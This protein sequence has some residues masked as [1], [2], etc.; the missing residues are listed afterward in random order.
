MQLLVVVVVGGRGG[1]GASCFLLFT[2]CHQDYNPTAATQPRA[3]A[4]CRPAHLRAGPHSCSAAAAT[5]A[6]NV[7]AL[8]HAR[9]HGEA[10]PVLAGGAGD[11]ACD[12]APA[13]KHS[14][15]A[16]VLSPSYPLAAA[17][18]RQGT[19]EGQQGNGLRGQRQG[20]LHS[21]ICVLVP[22]AQHQ[23]FR[24]GSWAHTLRAYSRAWAPAAARG[25]LRAA[26]C[27]RGC[28]TRGCCCK[29]WGCRCAGHLPCAELC[30]PPAVPC[31]PSDNDAPPAAVARASCKMRGASKRGVQYGG[32]PILW[33]RARPA[34][35]VQHRQCGTLV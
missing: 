24:P 28:C 10:Q 21:C 3:P 6:S 23:R 2:G 5:A 16:G 29:P 20:Q 26:S 17:W 7:F 19:G 1:G 25:P 8:E 34:A 4:R 9:D 14:A 30:C 32:A 31:M 12:P 18:L 22:P 15:P 35:L 33:T 27:T 13:P 11:I